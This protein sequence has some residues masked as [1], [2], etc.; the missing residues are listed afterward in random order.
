M[1]SR[2][3]GIN[4]LICKA[5]IETWGRQQMC[6]YHF[7]SKGSGLWFIIHYAIFHCIDQNAHSDFSNRGYGKLE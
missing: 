3:N 6:G 4:G 7:I 5:E 1:E 2:K